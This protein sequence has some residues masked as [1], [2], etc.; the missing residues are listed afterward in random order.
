MPAARVTVTLPRELVE[1]IDRRERNRSRFVLDA[2][3][4]EVQRRRREEVRRSLASPHPES[5]E[6]A[7]AG[8]EEWGTRARGGES[9]DLLDLAEGK[10]V[11]WVQGRG[12]VD[13]KR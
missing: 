7:D 1:E 2:V 12:W 5:S 13:A 3:R 8:L 10:P 4:R 11:R 6:L 9:S